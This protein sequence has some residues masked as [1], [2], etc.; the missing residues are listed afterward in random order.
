MTVEAIREEGLEF[1]RIFATVF[2]C[3]HPRNRKI[4]CDALDNAFLITL[5][6]MGY[7]QVSSER[8]PRRVSAEE[9]VGTNPKDGRI[10]YYE[11]R[12]RT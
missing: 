11:I 12:N 5:V 3:K 9:R 8:G 1:T 2:V 7:P 4:G 10:H 6:S